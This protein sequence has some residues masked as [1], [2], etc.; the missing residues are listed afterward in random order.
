VKCFYVYMLLCSDKSFYVGITSNIEQRL[1]QHEFGCDESCYTFKRRPLRCVHVS[2]FA[3]FD[4]A[5]AWEKHLKGW[6]RAKK[7]ALINNDWPEIRRMA[8]RPSR[9]GHPSRLAATRLA[10]QDDTEKPVSQ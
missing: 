9:R 8:K 10:P 6:S 3:N 1:G 2:E 4:D 7:L 5:V